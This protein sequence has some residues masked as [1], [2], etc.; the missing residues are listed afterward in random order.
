MSLYFEN[1]SETAAEQFSYK[2]LL[3][4]YRTIT[5]IVQHSKKRSMTSLVAFRVPFL[6]SFVAV[7]L[8]RP[9]SF[10][11]NILSSSVD[12][13]RPSWARARPA[14]RGE[15]LL[16]HGRP[17][18][19]AG[20]PAPVGVERGHDRGRSSIQLPQFRE[21]HLGFFWTFHIYFL[22]GPGPMSIVDSCFTCNA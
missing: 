6:Y 16:V 1:L 5:F 15:H 4:S 8:K 22:R 11:G 18:F 2:E 17:S 21:A 9:L 14:A 3:P 19:R 7:G 10:H 20:R 13:S 12:V